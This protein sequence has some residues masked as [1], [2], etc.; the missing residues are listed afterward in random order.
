M[1]DL[2]TGLEAG[3]GSLA[4]DTEQPR[5]RGATGQ[6]RAATRGAEQ[7]PRRPARADSPEPRRGSRADAQ[8]LR[9]TAPGES[10]PQRGKSAGA[11]PQPARGGTLGGAPA[12]KAGATGR[13][14]GGDAKAAS[15]TARSS[16]MRAVMGAAPAPSPAPHVE[17]D[18]ASYGR[19]M[20]LDD[21]PFNNAFGGGGAAA[22]ALE[23]A[24]D[25]Q[26]PA[27]LAPEPE[28]EAPEETPEQLR[29]R[30]IRELAAYGP[31]PA[32]LF[33]APLYWLRVMNRKRVLSV[34]LSALS[35]QRKRAD[36]EAQQALARLGEALYAQ[37]DSPDLAPLAKQMGAL[38]EADRRVGDAAAE[39]DRRRDGMANELSRL[40]R[41]LKREEAQA[42][43]L[44]AREAE[45]GARV[46]EIKTAARRADA[47]RRK[48]DAELEAIQ[49]GKTSAGAETW[50][51]LVAERD[52]R[53]G[54]F[55]TLGV[56]LR[57]LEDELSE[58][59]RDLTQRMR[60]IG[61]LQEERRA[62]ATGLERVQHKQR[63]SVGSAKGARLQALLSIAKEAQKLGLHELLPD[64]ADAV[65]AAVASADSAR[66]QEEVQRAATNSYDAVAYGRGFNLLMGSSVVLL[67]GLLIA[68][69]F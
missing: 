56:E 31:P 6:R 8:E 26:A 14:L 13:T 54:E 27:A 9:R 25:K 1:L 45:L 59:R 66:Q 48:A 21:N 36:D 17:A 34:Q 40:E 68:M 60:K 7:D 46:E 39:G 33:E 19:G 63:V 23:L 20:M 16:T 28:E 62:A 67:F 38:N 29:A 18:M 64:E 15:A 61:S 51:A 53:L 49:R 22:P 57:P 2:E 30:T 55:Q 42:A 58:L 69:F 24:V 65:T 44:R 10:S 4:L 50:G 12:P 5:A 11:S 47:A 3:G 32:K 41:D 37:R 35:A 43:P 52:A